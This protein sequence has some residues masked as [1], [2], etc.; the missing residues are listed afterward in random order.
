MSRVAVPRVLA[1]L[2]SE[3]IHH[4][5]PPP[6]RR[7]DLLKNEYDAAKLRHFMTTELLSVDTASLEATLMP[8]SKGG[9]L[10]RSLQSSPCG[11]YLLVQVA[12]TFSYSVPVSRFGKDVQLWSLAADITIAVASLPVDD[13]VP[14]SFDAW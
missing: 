6:V 5:I 10:V 4:P 14:I 9:R 7:S 1:V 2:Y 12:T 11:G 8:Q 3:Y 13:E